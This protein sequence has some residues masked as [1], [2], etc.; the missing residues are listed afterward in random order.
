M[1]YYAVAAFRR[2][3]GGS[4]EN[5]ELAQVASSGR[6]SVAGAPVIGRADLFTLPNIVSLAR[7][8][9]VTAAVLLYFAGYPRVFV[10]LGTAACLTD[11]LDGYLA[12]RLSQETVLGAMLDQA[13]D[14]FTTGIALALLV[15]AGGFPFLFL[16]IFLGRE[17]WV[18]TVRRYAAM[19]GLEIPSHVSGKVATGF[20]YWA[21]FLMAVALV[22]DVPV[23]IAAWLV[24]VA[25]AG[26]MVGLAFSCVAGWHYTRALAG[27]AQ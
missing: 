25:T 7:I 12:R 22:L 3:A 14:S 18:A 23:E 11:Y 2:A 16:V 5:P 19:S 13:A 1:R 17:F 15:I 8:V 26:M 24:S 9:G 27:T 4:A 6:G 10:V 20:I 21:M